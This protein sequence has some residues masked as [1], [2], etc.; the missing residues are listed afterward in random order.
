MRKGQKGLRAGAV[1]GAAAAMAGAARFGFLLV[2]SV[3]IDG[4]V[5]SS[6]DKTRLLATRWSVHPVTSDTNSPK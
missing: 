3:P 5:S 2:W 4:K 1:P 6:D